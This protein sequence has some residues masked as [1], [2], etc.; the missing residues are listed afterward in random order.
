GRLARRNGQGR[1]L[2]NTL[3]RFPIGKVIQRVGSQHEDEGGLTLGVQ[4]LE[5]VHGIAWARATNLAVI[6]H[7]RVNASDSQSH[8]G[9]AVL[10]RRNQVLEVVVARAC[11]GRGVLLRKLSGPTRLVPERNGRTLGPSLPPRVSCR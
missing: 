5:G 4:L 9:Q 3:R 8:H 10:R 2:P 7:E 6:D 11:G 1:E